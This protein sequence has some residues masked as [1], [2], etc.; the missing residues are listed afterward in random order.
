MVD[1]ALAQAIHD[2][3]YPALRASAPDPGIFA[4]FGLSKYASGVLLKSGMPAAIM[5]PL[6]MS[7]PAEAVLLAEPIYDPIS[8][9]FDAGFVG[10]GCRRGQIALALHD[11][12]LAHFARVG[13]TPMP[14]PEPGGTMHVA[15]I[16]MWS[17]K[18]G[19]NLTVYSQV[20]IAD[21]E[22]GS[23]PGA[24]VSVTTVQEG[25]TSVDN[26]ALLMSMAR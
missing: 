11:G 20:T 1:K 21:T 3:M 9:Q 10:L 18:K 22:G 24:A 23:V 2:V 14:T 26:L 8:G 6:F 12:V 17:A 5:E 16:E 19:P 15:A 25:V 4:D 7:N 13:P